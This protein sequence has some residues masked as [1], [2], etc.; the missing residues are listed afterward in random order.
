MEK[1]AVGTMACPNSQGSI[2]TPLLFNLYVHDMPKTKSNKF[3]YADDT[4]LACQDKDISNCE[5]TLE[6]DRETLN[7]YFKKWGLK[8]N[9][10]KSESIIIHLNNRQASTQR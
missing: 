5:K 2:L 8:P 9:H 7:L 6:E 3:Q 4:A 10:Q 1:K